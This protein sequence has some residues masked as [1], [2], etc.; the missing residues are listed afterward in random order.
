MHY[1]PKKEHNLTP[2]SSSSPLSTSS[3][4]DCSTSDKNITDKNNDNTE[5]ILI[6]ILAID[7]Y[8]RLTLTKTVK[9]ALSLNPED[10][11]I[12]Y[13]EKRNNNN[14]DKKIIL[15]FHH[16]VKKNNKSIVGTKEEEKKVD[17]WVLIKCNSGYNNDDNNNNN[18]NIYINSKFN[19]SNINNSISSKQNKQEE[20]N[21]NY[22]HHYPFEN[23]NKFYQTPII[24]IDNEPD[25]LLTFEYI[26]KNEGYNNVKS[27]SDSKSLLKHLLNI[28]DSSYYKLVITDIRMSQI[29]GIQLYQILKI[30]NPSIKIMFITSLDIQEITTI[31]PEIKSKDIIR[32]P[33]DRN[34]FIQIVNDKVKTLNGFAAVNAVA[35]A[36][37]TFIFCLLLS[38]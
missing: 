34:H 3:I 6:D 5:T 4:S 33:I 27:F 28:K 37:A 29:N 2:N 35:G 7:K 23:E 18:N 32:K 9:K 31:Y 16:I 17:N 14:K 38:I 25:L 8:S 36:T 10:K 21:N 26:L 19:K 20:E 12:V 11:I 15:K 30:L 13:Q 22:Q 1:N 24:L